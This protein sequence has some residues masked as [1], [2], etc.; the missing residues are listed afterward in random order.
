MQIIPLLM[1]IMLVIL[2]MKLCSV[3]LMPKTVVVIMEIKE[4]GIY[5]VE[6]QLMI[7]MVCI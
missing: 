4:S 1:L 3:L 7:V 5:Q 2:T 6:Y